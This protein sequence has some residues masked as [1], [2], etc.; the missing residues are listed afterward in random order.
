MRTEVDLLLQCACVRL[1]PDAPDRILAIVKDSPDWDALLRLAARH[2]LS[3][4]LYRH[5]SRACH[6]EEVAEVVTD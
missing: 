1:A 4:L 6:P 3:P 5:L 2:R